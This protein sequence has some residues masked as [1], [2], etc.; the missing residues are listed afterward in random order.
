[1]SGQLSVALRLLLEAQ[2]LKTGS[3]EA[4][5]ALEGVGTAGAQSMH[6]LDAQIV[7][8]GSSLSTRM[9]MG[10][11][12]VA[13]TFQK[14]QMD[15]ASSLRKLNLEGVSTFQRISAGAAQFGRS[16]D[17][18]I[19]PAISR[20][21]SNLR[22]L[23]EDSGR[24]FREVEGYT[25]HFN[26]VLGSLGV[27]TGAYGAYSL[28]ARSARLDRDLI[29]VRQ[30]AG[31]TPAQASALRALLF[32]EGRRTGQAPEALLGG[33]NRLIQSG[34]SW[35]QAR[36]TL[37]ALN[38]G[39]TIGRADAGVLARSLVVA[40]NAYQMNLARP[41]VA[42]SLLEQMTVAGRLGNAELENI[43]DIFP[44][45]GINASK[46]KLSFPRALG[47]VEGLS[48]VETQP[49]RLATLAESTL[50]VFTSERY[51]MQAQAGTGVRFYD[52][53]GGARDPFD[54]LDEMAGRYGKLKTDQARNQFIARGFGQMDLD[55]QRGVQSLLTGNTIAKVR[56]FS[57]LIEKAGGTFERDLPQSIDNAVD[58]AGRLKTSLSQAA[59]AFTTPINRTLADLI[60]WSQKSRA[61]G[62]AGLSPGQTTAATIA[63]GAGA[64]VAGGLLT[65]V[66]RR[67]GGNHLG[68][69][70]GTAAGLAAGQ[71]VEKAGLG[72]A[73]FVTNWPG[74]GAGSGSDLV[75]GLAGGAIA[76]KV[77][78]GGSASLRLLRAATVG[79]LFSGALGFGGA[80]A[81]GG[82]VAG[83]GAAGYGAGSLI[84]RG[85]DNTDFADRLGG[86]IALALSRVGNGEAGAAL[87]SR[88][89]GSKAE[90]TLRID[91]D[92]RA[93]VGAIT[94]SG[95]IDLN[96]ATGLHV[97]GAAP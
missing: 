18:G 28:A 88:L 65:S 73:V 56:E 87:D 54:V 79:Q 14:M 69:A 42:R 93:R 60:E 21:R 86:A 90:V 48:Q 68:G 82:L 13:V 22:G 29:G 46:A 72:T 55:T 16:V 58:Q 85:I 2:G 38:E 61:Q 11:Q 91:Q 51:K 44:R 8:V 41:G 12:R 30:T 17:A 5:K 32:S 78:T 67:I 76:S 70:V 59:D 4:K 71:A 45:V 92:G 84:Y 74:G 24:A 95:G 23:R 9:A 64:I 37:P 81:A 77:L 33:F 20:A 62:G 25:R 19:N 36:T 66:A 53:K 75:G 27:A 63:A 47:F 35:D 26:G 52:A 80:A 57:A 94:S 3:V 50:R 83:A 6:K 96:V 31:S 97:F 39:S 10:G 40:S 15:T 49:E 89:G 43:A 1:M 7:A 34:L